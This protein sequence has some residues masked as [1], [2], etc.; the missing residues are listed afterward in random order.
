MIP[1][2]YYRTLGLEPQ[3]EPNHIKEA[4]RRLAFEHH[5]DRNR[6][7]PAAAEKMKSINEAYAVLSNPAKRRKYDGLRR[8]FGAAACG[9]FRTSHSEQDIFS[10]SDINAVF[11]E[12]A[13][14]AGFRGVDDI[15]REFYGQT[16]QSFRFSRPRV[17]VRAFGFRRPAANAGT[18]GRPAVRE[19]LLERLF[20]L[21]LGGLAGLRPP[22]KGNDIRDRI[23]LDPKLAA[24]G[25]PYAYFHRQRSK[26]LV[27]KVPANVRE[28]QHIRLT[29]MGAVG[30]SGGN[31]GDLLLEV[32]FRRSVWGRLQQWARRVLKG[33]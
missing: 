10:G 33:R 13:R 23:R 26:K 16:Y 27:V 12:M 21:A 11:E 22:R 3:A 14:A 29:G 25:G 2:D 8:R 9:H 24:S 30:R 4:Y 1:D 7:N 20:R 28:G 19:R 31:N 15:F 5:P 32:R 6:G 17:T 18:R